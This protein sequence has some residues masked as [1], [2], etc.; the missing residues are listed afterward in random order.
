MWVYLVLDNRIN[1]NILVILVNR[2]GGGVLMNIYCN[3]YFNL[4]ISICSYVYLYDVFFGVII[5]IC[6]YKY[7]ILVLIFVLWFLFGFGFFFLVLVEICSDILK[8]L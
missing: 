2:K 1:D 8:G 5:D 6:I 4:I 7:G 3:G